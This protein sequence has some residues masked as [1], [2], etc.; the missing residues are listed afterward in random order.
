MVNKNSVHIC[1]SACSSVFDRGTWS[2]R[3]FAITILHIKFTQL[4][5][6]YLRLEVMKN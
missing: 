2:V 4:V 6:K 1:V 5:L 3:D